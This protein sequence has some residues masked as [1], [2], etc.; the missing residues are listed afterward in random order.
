M[1]DLSVLNEWISIIII[2]FFFKMWCHSFTLSLLLFNEFSDS[3]GKGKLYLIEGAKPKKKKSCPCGI[4]KVIYLQEML[5]YSRNSFQSV[6]WRVWWNYLGQSH[7]VKVSDCNVSKN[8]ASSSTE[9]KAL[10]FHRCLLPF[11]KS[12]F[13]HPVHL[14]A[15][16]VTWRQNSNHVLSAALQSAIVPSENGADCCEEY[17]I[18]AGCNWWCD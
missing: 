1:K 17:F 3:E 12:F 7:T 13:W 11:R 16:A 18:T 5:H 2:P 6:M 10:S 14:A 8:T 9:T 15:I 4:Y